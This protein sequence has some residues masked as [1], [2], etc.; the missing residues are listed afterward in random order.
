MSNYPHVIRAI[1]SKVERLSFKQ[2]KDWDA[3]AQLSVSSDRMEEMLLHRAADAIAHEFAGQVLKH[4]RIMKYGEPEG[5]VLRLDAVA[6][7]FDELLELL[8]R[9]YA[10]GQSDGINRSVSFGVPA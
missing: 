3:I 10:E 9:A 6:L 2:V 1:A 4:G 7:R 8:Y 5:L